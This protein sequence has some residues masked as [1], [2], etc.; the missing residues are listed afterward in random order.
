MKKRPRMPARPGSLLPLEV[1]AVGHQN[2]DISRAYSRSHA[3]M[4][5]SVVHEK[6][7]HPSHCSPIISPASYTPFILR[8]SQLDTIYFLSE[9]PRPVPCYLRLRV[10][11]TQRKIAHDTTGRG[12]LFRLCRVVPHRALKSPGADDHRGAN[13]NLAFAP[14]CSSSTKTKDR[15]RG[16]FR[17]RIHLPGSPERV[18][19]LH[20]STN[21]LETSDD[22]RYVER[23][24]GSAFDGQRVPDW[25][26]R[27]TRVRVDAY[28][29]FLAPFS[30]VR[31]LE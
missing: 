30:C 8:V 2:R 24:S 21:R 7:G 26:S 13:G 20:G 23:R 4:S 3:S 9:Q 16:E 11:T 31:H 5:T 25:P 29:R 6:P 22:R 28:E 19:R 1:E 15:D 12:S 17:E 10:I 27:V 18:P 14:R